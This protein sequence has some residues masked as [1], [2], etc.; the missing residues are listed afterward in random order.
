MK[1]YQDVQIH[2][3][4]HLH[5]KFV[6]IK[7]SLESVQLVATCF[8]KKIKLFPCVG[9]TSTQ[10]IYDPTQ[11]LIKGYCAFFSKRMEKKIFMEKPKN[12]ELLKKLLGI[13]VSNTKF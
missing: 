9:S 7:N 10:R 3:P 13:A 6:S 4:P 12:K 8:S 5:A 11:T 1:T 2:L